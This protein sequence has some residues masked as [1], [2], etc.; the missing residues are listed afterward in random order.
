MKFLWVP[1]LILRR[2]M[3]VAP[4]GFEKSPPA[5]RYVHNMV[6]RKLDGD[7]IK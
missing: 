6:D 3:I 2:A 7:A 5:S 1:M 4:S